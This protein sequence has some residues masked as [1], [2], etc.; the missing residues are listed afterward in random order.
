MLH[1][2]NTVVRS[3]NQP[4]NTIELFKPSACPEVNYKPL[5]GDSMVPIG[6]RTDLSWTEATSSPNGQT[7]DHGE[8][9]G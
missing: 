2:R 7:V 4:L 3:H 9:E 8:I 6:R 5:S 1:S